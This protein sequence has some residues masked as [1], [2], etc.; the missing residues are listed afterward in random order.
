MAHD[1]GLA[2]RIREILG[3]QPNIVEKKMFGGIAFMEQG[4]MACGVHKND[5]LAIYMVVDFGD[6]YSSF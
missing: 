1:E 3:E 2:Q 4:N 6:C 5:L